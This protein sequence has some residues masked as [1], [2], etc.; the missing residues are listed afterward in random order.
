MNLKIINIS[1]FKFLRPEDFRL[2]LEYQTK[3]KI[4]P[5]KKK[6]GDVFMAV[7]GGNGEG[8]S[9][10]ILREL[11]R[12]VS[13]NFKEHRIIFELD[14]NNTSD[15]HKYTIHILKAITTRERDWFVS[16]IFNNDT[17]NVF[18]QLT[19]HMYRKL[20]IC[21]KEILTFKLNTLLKNGH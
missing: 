14:I 3:I 13:S 5:F 1:D 4:K 19:P 7:G 12:Q 6:K 2:Y 11:F 21:N 8:E 9:I 16:T 18:K 17:E 10:H 20:E 15:L